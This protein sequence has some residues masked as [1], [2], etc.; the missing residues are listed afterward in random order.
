MQRE[1]GSP[2]TGDVVWGVQRNSDGARYLQVAHTAFSAAAM[3]GLTL[4]EC[5]TWVESEKVS[6]INET[7]A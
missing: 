2:P 7:Q 1:L 6:D 3:C 4:S 5:T